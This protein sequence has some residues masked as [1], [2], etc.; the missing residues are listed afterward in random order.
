MKVSIENIQDW[1]NLNDIDYIN[2]F[3]LSKKSWLKAGGIIKIF[4]TPKSFKETIKLNAFFSKNNINFYILG[5]ISN[6]IIRDG[7][8][9]TPFINFSKLNKI[10]ELKTKSGLFIYVEAGVTIPRFAK[11]VANKGYTGT[12]GLLGIPGS[13]GGGL[14]MN[15]SSFDNCIS[16]CL[17]KVAS[18]NYN[19]RVVF[20]KKSLINFSWRT[21]NFQ[22]NKNT[23]LGGYFYFPPKKFISKVNIEEKYKK[24][25]FYRKKYQEKDL[26]NLGSLFATK[27]LYLEIKYNSILFFIL[28]IIFR[29]NNFLFSQN[30]S[31]SDKLG[32]NRS[33]LISIYN[34]FLKIKNNKFSV[35][36][37]TINCL[38]N[39]GS[40]NA[41]EAIEFVLKFKKKVKNKVKLENII[42]DKIL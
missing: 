31:T 1:L 15:A 10:K 32:K 37:K 20:E 36:T 24:L 6:T 26:P 21:S 4:I 39:N 8:I 23:I 5:N 30:F 17:K 35:S 9:N 19:N 27:N 11:F 2:D 33:K 34:F 41:N 7:V 3:D 42:L 38:V 12:E 13:M 22:I 29:I 40:H 14:F 18:L 28:Y 25:M 16:D